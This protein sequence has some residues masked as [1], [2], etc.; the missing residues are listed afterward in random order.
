MNSNPFILKKNNR[1]IIISLQFNI[2]MRSIKGPSSFLKNQVR[3]NLAKALLS[4]T[5][6]ISIAILVIFR[7]ITTLQLGIL[8]QVVLMLVIFP[9]VAFFYY[10]RKYLIYNGGWQGEKQVE[11]LL[12]SNLS[13]DF[14]LISGL[15][16][17]FRGD[18]DQVVLGPK[19][20]LVLETKLERINF[21]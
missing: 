18:I 8:E 3:N 6:F 12:K 4:I 7:L 15:N 17:A 21:L 10:Q 14:F 2:D 11:R 13:D 5:L 1:K 19:G 20:V 9:L 16:L